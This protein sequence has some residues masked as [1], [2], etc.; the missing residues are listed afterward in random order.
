MS[1][2]AIFMSSIDTL[3]VIIERSLERKQYSNAEKYIKDF[4]ETV[5]TCFKKGKYDFQSA[6]ESVGGIFYRLSIRDDYYGFLES[7]IFELMNGLIASEHWPAYTVVRRYY[8]YLL[9]ALIKDRNAKGVKNLLRPF[10]NFGNRL[11]A[12]A[13]NLNTV[14]YTWFEQTAFR[15]FEYLYPLEEVDAQTAQTILHDYVYLLRDLIDYQRVGTFRILMTHLREL[16]PLINVGRSSLR[17]ILLDPDLGDVFFYREDLL[18]KNIYRFDE[19][20]TTFQE[21]D[22]L[23]PGYMPMGLVGRIDFALLDSYKKNL[24]KQ[25]IFAAMVYSFFKKDYAFIS[26]YLELAEEHHSRWERATRGPLFLPEEAGIIIGLK[27]QILSFGIFHVRYRGFSLYFDQLVAYFLMIAYR[28]Q[29]QQAVIDKLN[30]VSKYSFVETLREIRRT[31]DP[32]IFSALKYT[33]QLNEKEFNE[34]MDA[35]L[36]LVP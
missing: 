6:E 9:E 28:Q 30:V 4:F 1:N 24:I 2:D 31:V 15:P 11:I 16:H 34:I 5:Y 21:I 25:G 10:Q 12:N 32:V 7:K 29:R 13:K 26:I 14:D 36:T 33:E 23:I 18:G 27:A 20:K 3:T 35:Y 17:S 22:D 8:L 19:I